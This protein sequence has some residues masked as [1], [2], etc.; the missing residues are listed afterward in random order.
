MKKFID[1]IHEKADKKILYT[2]HAIRQMNSEKRL[3]TTE[4]VEEKIYKGSIIEE[5]PDDKRGHSCLINGRIKA[6]AIHVVCA[7]KDEYLA[8]ITSYIPDQKIWNNEYTKRKK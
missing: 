3:I 8:I 1:I 4:E 7:P 2:I 6:R 5:Y